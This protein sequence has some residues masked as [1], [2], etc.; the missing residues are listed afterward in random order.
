MQPVTFSTSNSPTRDN[1]YP[2]LTKEQ[3]RETRL[4]IDAIGQQLFH[5]PPTD[6]SRPK[7]ELEKSQ[8]TCKDLASAV[9]TLKD[10]ASTL[11][12]EKQ[13]LMENLAKSKGFNDQYHG[14]I[15]SLEDRLRE[16]TNE[17][18]RLE[19]QIQK[20]KRDIAQTEDQMNQFRTK[21]RKEVSDLQTELDAY[22]QK[23]KQLSSTIESHEDIQ[24]LKRKN[25]LLQLAAETQKATIKRLNESNKKLIIENQR[26]R[27][28][29]P[30]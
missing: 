1:N 25:E 21:K 16:K 15:V 28:G 26:L 17:I 24:A 9:G 11:E 19:E 27:A 2:I 20:L 10:K 30:R 13:N 18:K 6:P 12:L 23:V 8:L 3:L 22:Q 14:K 7:L 4:R 29:P 5:L